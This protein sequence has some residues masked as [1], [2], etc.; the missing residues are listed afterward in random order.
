LDGELLVNRRPVVIF[1]TNMFM[2]MAEGV[3]VIEWIEELIDTKPVVLCPE[4]VFKELESLT[5]QGGA[6]GRRAS[7]ARELAL[8]YCERR[9]RY[10]TG[11]VDKEIIAVAVQEKEKGSTVIVATSD[12]SLRKALREIGISTI[13]YRESQDKLEIEHA[14]LI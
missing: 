14:P 7:F 10:E 3:P 11:S 1:D 12:R 13:F 9:E 5:E 4:G 2:L 8:R 6:L